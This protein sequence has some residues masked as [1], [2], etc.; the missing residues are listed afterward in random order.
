VRCPRDWQSQRCPAGVHSGRHHWLLATPRDPTS[1][2]DA[3]ERLAKNG[4]L[5]H[6]MAL[7]SREVAL[8]RFTIDIHVA[9]TLKIYDSLLSG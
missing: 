8:Q 4:P 5:R 1:F 6:S 2:A 9:A 3:I 7:R